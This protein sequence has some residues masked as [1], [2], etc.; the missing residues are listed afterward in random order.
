MAW[1]VRYCTRYRS[2]ELGGDYFAICEIGAFDVL[3]GIY[4]FAPKSLDMPEVSLCGYSGSDKEGYPAVS[5]SN[6]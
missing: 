2:V 3:V 6:R 5:E 4:L 1:R